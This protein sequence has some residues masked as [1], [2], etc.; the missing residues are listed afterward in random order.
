MIEQIDDQFGCLLATIEQSGQA[1][2]TVVLFTSDHGEALGDHGLIQKGWR[3]YEGLDR[4][5]MIWWCPGRFARQRSSALV[6]LTDIAPTLL[7]LGGLDVPH[8]MHGRTL[9]PL[10][11]SAASTGAAAPHRNFVRCEYLNAL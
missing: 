11:E 3:I 4:V 2:H 6:E 5:P 8:E 7:Q 10:L 9:L 1:D